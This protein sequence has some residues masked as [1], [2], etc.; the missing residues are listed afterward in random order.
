LFNLFIPA[1]I[2]LSLFS[3][4]LFFIYFLLFFFFFLTALFILSF[5]YLF[6]LSHLSFSLLF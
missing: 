1:P 4:T 2:F 5:L 6:W 3:Q